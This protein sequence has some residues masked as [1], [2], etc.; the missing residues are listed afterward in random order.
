MFTPN[1]QRIS[2]NALT[3]LHHKFKENLRNV[4]NCRKCEEM[5]RNIKKL[6][7]IKINVNRL[8]KITRNPQNTKHVFWMCVILKPGSGV[9]GPC[10]EQQ[11]Q[12]GATC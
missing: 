8:T 4:K 7:E 12:K 6:K 3:I 10:F 2:K 5:Q 11:C 9:S 1:S